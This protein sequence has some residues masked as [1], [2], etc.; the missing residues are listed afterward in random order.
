MGYIGAIWYVWYDIFS[1][2][3]HNFTCFSGMAVEMNPAVW[4]GQRPV[5]AALA[6]LKS[7][8]FASSNGDLSLS[9]HC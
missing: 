8:L 1:V 7:I 2:S 9:R 5:P 6:Y 3:F 4:I